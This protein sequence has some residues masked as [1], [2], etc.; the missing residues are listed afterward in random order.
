MSYDV[1]RSVWLRARYEMLCARKDVGSDRER[2]SSDL[3]RL[4]F[5]VEVARIAQVKAGFHVFAIDDYA[6]RIYQY[7]P[8]LP[9][10]PTLEMLQTDGT[11]WYSIISLRGKSLGGLTAKYG[12]TSY[13]SGND[14]SSFLFYY[15][16]KM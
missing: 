11:R 15:N 4:D 7:E 9:Y 14:K 10:Y 5:G 1:S 2:F 16:L 13:S 8:G 12:R 3:L 6:S